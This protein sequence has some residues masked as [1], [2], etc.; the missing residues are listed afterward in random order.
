[1]KQTPLLS[2]AQAAGFKTYPSSENE[3]NLRTYVTML[4]LVIGLGHA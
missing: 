4:Q 1:M 3:S 2:I